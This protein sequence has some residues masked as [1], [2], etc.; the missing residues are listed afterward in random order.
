MM[1]SGAE[2]A[3]NGSVLVYA[4]V[5]EEMYLCRGGVKYFVSEARLQ[6]LM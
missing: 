2:F 6:K 1:V 3:N 5:G 4:R